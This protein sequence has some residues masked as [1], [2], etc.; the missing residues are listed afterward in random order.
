LKQNILPDAGKVTMADLMAILPFV[1]NMVRMSLKGSD[2][3]D[4]LE[5]SVY[6]YNA[7]ERKGKF[8]QYSGKQQ[9][10]T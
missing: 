4:M 6:D 10:C 2:L 9:V 1:N 8:L 5:W 7:S 3:L